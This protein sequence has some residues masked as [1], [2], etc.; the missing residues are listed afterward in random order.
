MAALI[1]L[2]SHVGKI[3]FKDGRNMNVLFVDEGLD[4]ERL[5]SSLRKRRPDDRFELKHDLKQAFEALFRVKFDVI[6]M[7]MWMPGDDV[8]VPGSED[9][10]GIAAGLRL[11]E[12]VRTA[13]NCVNQATPIVVLTGLHETEL[14]SVPGSDRLSGYTLLSKPIRIDDLLSVLIGHV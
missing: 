1:W 5:V 11:S 2:T 13:G 12:F 6:V 8:L 3:D 7:D 10:H 9:D 4:V 14:K